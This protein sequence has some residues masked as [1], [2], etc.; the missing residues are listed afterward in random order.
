MDLKAIR[1]YT[2]AQVFAYA[3]R[4]AQMN[5]RYVGW[6][7]VCEGEFFLRVYAFRETKS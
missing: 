1:E 6:L 2:P 7:D 4:E 3:Q 5:N